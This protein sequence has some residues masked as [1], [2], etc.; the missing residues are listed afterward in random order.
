MEIN[1]KTPQKKVQYTVKF[2]LDEIVEKLIDDGWRPIVFCKDCRHYS[3]INEKTG[4]C[5]NTR[6]IW[7]PDEFCSDGEKKNEE[8]KT[9]QRI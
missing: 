8:T 3:P 5:L 9:S 1:K 7:H 6:V 4:I 2:D